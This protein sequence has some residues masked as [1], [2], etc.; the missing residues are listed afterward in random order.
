MAVLRRKALERRS[1]VGVRQAKGL[2]G[3]GAAVNAAACTAAK[4]RQAKWKW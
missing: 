3:V 1:V 2:L 4:P